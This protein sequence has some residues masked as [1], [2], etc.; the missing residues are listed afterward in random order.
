[1]YLNYL[2]DHKSLGY[3]DLIDTN[4]DRRLVLITD[5]TFLIIKNFPLNAKNKTKKFIFITILGSAI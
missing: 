4:Y 2:K 3:E 1:M 5:L